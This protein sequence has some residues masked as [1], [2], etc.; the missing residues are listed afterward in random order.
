MIAVQS[1][2]FT[3]VCVGY[4][5]YSIVNVSGAFMLVNMSVEL[6][7]GIGGTDLTALGGTLLLPFLAVASP[8]AGR[9]IDLT[10]NYP[11]V[12]Y[13]GATIAVIALFG[14]AFLVREPRT[15]KLYEFKQISMG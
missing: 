5:L 6:C 12:F 15:G 11:T 2:S 3:A 7:P 4:A 10:G 9:I 14:F 8:L 1:R 13:I